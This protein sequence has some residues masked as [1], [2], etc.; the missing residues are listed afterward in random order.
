MLKKPI[1]YTDFF[2]QPRKR[3]LYFHISTSR[4]A[5]MVMNE[6]VVEGG[7][8]EGDELDAKAQERVRD[9]LSRRIRGV[10]E[11]GK[12]REIIELFDWLVSNAYGIIED[13]GET[14]SQSEEIYERWM[15]SASYD[16]FFNNLLEDTDA[17][18]E[19]V[20]GVFPKGMAQNLPKGDPEFASHRKAQAAQG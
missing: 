8:E 7:I 13:D 12:G 17:M 19:F 10:M 2:G 3:T 4:A 16:A 1:E 5:R 6:T 20:N 15:N 14:F 18:T 11:R 9:G